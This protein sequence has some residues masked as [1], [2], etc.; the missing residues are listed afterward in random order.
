[1]EGAH[2][3]HND[4]EYRVLAFIFGLLMFTGGTHLWITILGAAGMAWGIL[5]IL[6]IDVYK[7]SRS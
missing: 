3:I 1:M 5:R 6:W 4:I 7:A 2:I